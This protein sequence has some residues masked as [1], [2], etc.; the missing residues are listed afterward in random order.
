LA[1]AG[2]YFEF[3]EGPCSGQAAISISSAMRF[4]LGQ[5]AVLSELRS[6]HDTVS[7][8]G[9]SRE[10]A[11]RLAE[12]GGGWVSGFL[13]RLR[14][15]CVFCPLAQGSWHSSGCAGLQFGSNPETMTAYE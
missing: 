8:N 13:P 9:T 15:G 10:F 5:G 4:R 14:S 6:G 2:G 12:V 7:K 1:L 11:L 3:F